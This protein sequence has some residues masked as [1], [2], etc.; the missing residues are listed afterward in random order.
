MTTAAIIDAK[1]ACL[2]NK[3]IGKE[4]TSL[5]WNHTQKMK[6]FVPY[7][8]VLS[9]GLDSAHFKWLEYFPR[10][11][12]ENAPWSRCLKTLR[13][14]VYTWPEGK[15]YSRGPNDAQRWWNGE[16]WVTITDAPPCG[17]RVV[18]YSLLLSDWR[19]K[20]VNIKLVVL[21]GRSA[22]RN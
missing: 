2:R 15:I 1:F 11:N 7:K 16:V 5:K 13:S 12:S 18:E 6:S 20:P 17:D 3:L 19:T 21:V 14:V 8:R 10:L 9:F 4:T 22:H